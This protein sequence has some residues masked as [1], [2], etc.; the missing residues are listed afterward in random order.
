MTTNDN[1]VLKVSN[2]RFYIAPVGTARPTTLADMKA[3]AAP[4]KEMGNTSLDQIF[5]I[6]SQGGEVTNLGSVQNPNLRQSISPRTE[7]FGINL[8]EW[9]EESLKLYYGANAV[10]L[11][12]GAIE[13]PT[14]PVP[15]EAA[16]FVALYDGENVA[17][18]YAAK[19]SIF[20]SDDI[21]ISDTNS[22]SHLPIKVTALNNQGAASA[23]TVV[24]PKIDKRAA[25]A[26]AT[27][28]SGGVTSVAVTDGGNGYATA[29][30]VSFAGAGSGAAAT[31]TIVGGK[32]TS[33]SVTSAGTGYTTAPTVTVAAPAA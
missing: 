33:I 23:I 9:T 12:D 24:P 32:V 8:L 6:S 1:A 27:V 16:F 11:V 22:L 20:R 29:P 26:T 18:F 5:Q 15:T 21:A 10:V 4:W 13:A 2:A 30:A 19:S 3:P 28:S 31:A 17:G 14:T 25:T 7:S